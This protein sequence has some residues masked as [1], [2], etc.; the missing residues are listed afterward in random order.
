LLPPYSRQERA[1]TL[2]RLQAKRLSSFVE[3]KGK[4]MGVLAIVLWA[5]AL[6][7]G[8]FFPPLFIPAIYATYLWHKRR[9]LAR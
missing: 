9:K 5:I 6:S 1:C 4:V 2:A 8:V 7:A 3:V